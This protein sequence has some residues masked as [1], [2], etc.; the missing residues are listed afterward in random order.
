MHI[1]DRLA[2][3]WVRGVNWSE[4]SFNKKCGIIFITIFITFDVLILLPI[5][6]IDMLFG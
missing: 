6:L 1:L 3:A 2:D 4:L 5:T